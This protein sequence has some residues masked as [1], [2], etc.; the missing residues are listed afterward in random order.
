M[1]EMRGNGGRELRKK[2]ENKLEESK[3]VNSSGIVR[4]D[5]GLIDSNTGSTRSLAVTLTV[6]S[7]IIVLLLNTVPCAHESDFTKK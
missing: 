7:M 3:R 2:Y 5:S 4:K 1:R 6:C